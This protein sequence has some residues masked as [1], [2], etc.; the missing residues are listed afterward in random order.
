MCDQTHVCT[1]ADEEDVPHQ[2]CAWLWFERDPSTSVETA[3]AMH[4][5]VGKRLKLLLAIFARQL[6][7]QTRAHFAFAAADDRGLLKATHTQCGAGG[8]MRCDEPSA[9]DLFSIAD[10]PCGP[11]GE[12]HREAETIAAHEAHRPLCEARSIVER[13][14]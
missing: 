2:S 5:L 13:G 1:T 3:R 12:R 11:I 6:A 10:V 9:S 8:R 14:C 4:R 7:N